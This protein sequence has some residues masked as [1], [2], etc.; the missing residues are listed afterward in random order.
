[1]NSSFDPQKLRKL[2]AEV[3]EVGRLCEG[4]IFIGDIAVYLHAINHEA[5]SAYAEST[6]NADFYISLPSLSALREIEELT[7]NPHLSKLE[8]KRRGEFSFGVYAERQSALPVPYDVVAAHAVQYDGVSVAALED[9]LVLKLEAAVDRHGSEH[10]RKDAKDVIRILL[11]AAEMKFDPGR[12]VAHM[13]PAHFERLGLIVKG[14]EFVSMALGN[15]KIAKGLRQTATKVFERLSVAYGSE[16]G[17][18]YREEP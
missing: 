12:A 2:L 16:H 6:K 7:P 9:L 5:T 15:A 11:L 8:F 4:V 1:V 10:G 18:H 14:P 13:R 3:F 17:D